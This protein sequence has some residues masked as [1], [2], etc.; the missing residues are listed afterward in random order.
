MSE[1]KIGKPVGEVRIE[2]ERYRLN[3]AIEESLRL[4]R[5]LD[6]L[7]V[8]AALAVERA[9]KVLTTFQEA[10]MQLE[11]LQ[12]QMQQ[13]NKGLAEKGAQ[14]TSEQLIISLLSTGF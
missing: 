10:L 13:L 8:E 5:E 14:S 2:N 1:N 3:Y 4:L 11:V 12:V 7:S 6:G 9:D